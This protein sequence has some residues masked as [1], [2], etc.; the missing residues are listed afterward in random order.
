[1]KINAGVELKTINLNVNGMS[2]AGCEK[3]VENALKKITGV[4]TVKADRIDRKVEVTT[5]EIINDESIFRVAV[6]EAGYTVLD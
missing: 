4:E 6:E 1:M 5:N 2:C 3:A